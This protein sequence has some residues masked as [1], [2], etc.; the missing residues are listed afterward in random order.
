MVGGGLVAA[1]HGVPDVRFCI[2]GSG[3]PP[4]TVLATVGLSQ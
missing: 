4:A 1:D 3:A 2:A